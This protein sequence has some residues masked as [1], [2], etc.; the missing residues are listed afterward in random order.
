MSGGEQHRQRPDASMS[1]LSELA[2]NA[3]EP[4]YRTT[5]ASRRSPWRFALAVMLA[6][7]LI[8]VAILTTTASRSAVAD[9]RANLMARVSEEEQR[10]DQ[11]ATEVAQLDA[12]ND[13]LQDA[14][15]SD[16]N[17]A[18]TIQRLNL[19]TGGSA[20][21]GPGIVIRATDAPVQQDSLR[22]LIFDSDLS[23]LV[24]GLWESGAEAVAIN[25]H[26][27]TS[28]TP[29]RS[30]GSAITVDYVSISPPY[31]IEAIGDPATLQARFAQTSAGSWW[32]YI[33]DN[34]GI[35][36]EINASSQSLELPADPAMVLM[37]AES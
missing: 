34:Y 2:D 15:V 1:L 14:L 13:R 30:A 18:A 24:N 26:R 28:M 11:L 22:G 21:H 12:E 6:S 23:R 29:I 35:G 36:F 20:V 5:R 25:G 33:H 10:R 32:Q 27:V 31:R 7:A 4:E 8:V 3:L 9:E 17:T 16:P 19:S 37:N